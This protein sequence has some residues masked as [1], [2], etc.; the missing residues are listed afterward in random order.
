[1]ISIV[2]ERAPILF[3]IQ[4]ANRHHYLH[5]KLNLDAPLCFDFGTTDKQI[6]AGNGLPES[7]PQNGDLPKSPFA[8]RQR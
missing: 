8:H 7:C 3:L 2:A 5:L 1:M 4:R 6:L